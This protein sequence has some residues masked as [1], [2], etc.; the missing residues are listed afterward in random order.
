MSVLPIAWRGNK[1]PPK[2]TSAR[3]SEV[4]FTSLSSSCAM[5]DANPNPNSCTHGL[6]Q[7]F[8]PVDIIIFNFEILFKSSSV[9][10]F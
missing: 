6:L 8:S 2:L 7:D 1:P 3:D 4:L 10:T 5:R 9:G